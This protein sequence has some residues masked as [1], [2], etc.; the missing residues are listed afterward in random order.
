MAKKW[1]Q[2]VRKLLRTALAVMQ[3]RMRAS[4]ADQ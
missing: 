4:N 1:G 2:V 3:Q